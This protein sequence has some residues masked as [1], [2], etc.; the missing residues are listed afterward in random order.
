MKTTLQKK[1]LKI[2]FQTVNIHSYMFK[3]INMLL[4]TKKK[5]IILQHYRSFF[6]AK[7]INCTNRYVNRKVLQV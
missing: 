4:I 5:G 2:N 1:K 3:H 6:L 7:T